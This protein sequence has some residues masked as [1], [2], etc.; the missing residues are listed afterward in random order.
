MARAIEDR[1]YKA[2]KKQTLKKLSALREVARKSTL[3]S[4]KS[5]PDMCVIVKTVAKKKK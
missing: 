3:E 4:K 5:D 2:A 1:S